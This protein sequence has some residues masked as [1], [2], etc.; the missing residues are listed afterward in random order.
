MI[1][2]FLPLGKR[3]KRGRKCSR[4]RREERIEGI[5]LEWEQ[6]KRRGGVLAP[7][8]EMY[9]IPPPHQSTT[10]PQSPLFWFG[11]LTGFSSILHRI[12]LKRMYCI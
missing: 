5:D 7:S 1:P 3:G 8:N 4:R 12:T 2:L 11:L 9:I 6:G 10:A